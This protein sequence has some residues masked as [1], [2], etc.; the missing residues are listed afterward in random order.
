MAVPGSVNK[1]PTITRDLRRVWAL[2]D[3][4]LS[5]SLPSCILRILYTP[6]T[7]SEPYRSKKMLSWNLDRSIS[8]PSCILRILFTPTV[9]S[10]EPLL[11]PPS[12]SK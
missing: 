9:H 10:S 2:S 4:S 3:R 8:L 11:L 12:E 5:V 1:L 6:T 7:H